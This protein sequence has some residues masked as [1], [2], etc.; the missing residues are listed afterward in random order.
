[1][2]KLIHSQTC[3]C[4]EAMTPKTNPFPRRLPK[5]SLDWVCRRFGGGPPSYGEVQILLRDSHG[6][7][8]LA[9]VWLPSETA[10]ELR[11]L[12]N[13]SYLIKGEEGVVVFD[14]GFKYSLMS[15]AKSVLDL[16][17]VK[18]LLTAVLKSRLDVPALLRIA[19]LQK[20]CR[21]PSLTPLPTA[22]TILKAVKRHFP[23]Q[24]IREIA[25]SHWHPDHS[26]DAPRL[27]QMAFAEWGFRPP[28]RIGAEDRVR[29]SSDGSLG[30]AEQVFTHACFEPGSWVWGQDLTDGAS[31]TGTSFRAISH[32]GHTLGSHS[33]VSE[34]QRVVIREG[35]EF[36]LQPDRPFLFSLLVMSMKTMN[37]DPGSF[38]SSEQKLRAVVGDRR[39]LVYFPH[40]QYKPPSILAST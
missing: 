34:E 17:V 7:P 24:K 11:W 19:S 35:V 22:P 20:R 27:Q 33:L 3:R 13:W 8:T 28:L 5:T 9:R 4:G 2:S 15:S 10:E 39:F 32:P 21:N 12:G 40:A 38:R 18:D 23:N 1:M 31:I 25:L 37:E 26:E 29:P 6:T 30:G 16:K 14:T 36:M